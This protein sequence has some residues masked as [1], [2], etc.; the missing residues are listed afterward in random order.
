MRYCEI[1]FP[2]AYLT[3][4]FIVVQPIGIKPDDGRFHPANDVGR[5]DRRHQLAQNIV[6]HFIVEY[7]PTI[8]DLSLIVF[9]CAD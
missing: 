1:L 2:L 8:A 3:E 6:G 9:F 5:L 7:D 4:Q